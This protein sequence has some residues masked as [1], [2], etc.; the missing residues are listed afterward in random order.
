MEPLPT[1]LL[2][3]LAIIAGLLCL[4]NFFESPTLNLR[5]RFG[6]LLLGP[7]SIFF[8]GMYFY[9]TQ[10]DTDISNRQFWVRLGLAVLFAMIVIWN[11]YILK[12]RGRN[13]H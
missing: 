5:L 6:L 11:V 12:Q 13:D 2:S 10:F 1:W 7:W 8:G 4:L 3:A 9:W